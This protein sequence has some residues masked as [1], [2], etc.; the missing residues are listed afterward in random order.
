MFRHSLLFTILFLAGQF[1]VFSQSPYQ[2]NWKKESIIASIGLST[3]GS[4]YLVGN[5]VNGFNVEQINNLDRARVNS[6]DRVATFNQSFAADKASDHLA[7]GAKLLPL[8]FLADEKGRNNFQEIALLYAETY[9]VA[10]GLTT[11]TKSAVA[12]PR[13]FLFNEEV[14][15]DDKLGR[16][17]RYSFFSGHTSKTAAMSFFTAKVYADFY[18]ES[19]W[20]PFV[21]AAAAAV[22]AVTGY[23]RVKSGKHYPSDVMVG[24]VVGALSGILVP[25]LHKRHKKSD[26]FENLHLSVGAGMANMQLVF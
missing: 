5:G 10:N 23:M 1:T 15:I 24:Y 17:A 4:S 20:R 13:P 3:W 18:P 14:P 7:L 2:F 12:R 25:Q 19:Q 16:G 26:K 11:L 9:M 22:P 21:W 6:F 8:V